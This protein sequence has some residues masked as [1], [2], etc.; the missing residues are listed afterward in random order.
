MNILIIDTDAQRRA[1][2]AFGLGCA[3]FEAQQATDAESAQMQMT[4]HPTDLVLLFADHLDDH[5]QSVTRTLKD[6]SRAPRPIVVAVLKEVTPLETAMAFELGLRDCLALPIAPHSLIDKVQGWLNVH[7]STNVL[8][9]GLEVDVDSGI[10]SRAGTS[11]TLGPTERRTLAALLE[12]PEWV[13]TRE[14]LFRRVHTDK[15][16]DPSRLIDV[17]ICRLRSSLKKLGCADL[18][19]TVR[20]RGYRFS[21]GRPPARG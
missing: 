16:A 13:L 14:H 15:D 11:L 6:G 21:L 20:G 17:S 3:G 4:Q 8:E 12:F 7:R 1:L 9:C 18:L 10:L 2:H 19:Q 5:A